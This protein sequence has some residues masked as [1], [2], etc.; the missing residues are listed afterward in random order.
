MT[1]EHADLRSA[2]DAFYAAFAAGDTAA[3]DALW[4]IDA[5]LSCDHP[6]MA[7]LEGRDAVMDV[8]RR[9]LAGGGAP[10][11]HATDVHCEVD[12]DSATVSCR[13]R[14]DDAAMAAVNTFAREG[15]V[16]RMTSHRAAPA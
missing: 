8:W 14:I 16:W 7:T 5:P 3:M 6:G 15:G 4:A 13:E 12:G 9:I 2:N 10:G 1:D 11:I